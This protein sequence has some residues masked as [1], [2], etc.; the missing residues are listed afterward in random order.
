MACKKLCVYRC[1]PTDTQVEKKFEKTIP[2]KGTCD[3][4][5]HDCDLV[6]EKIIED[7]GKVGGAGGLGIGA[8]IGIGIGFAVGGPLGAL[9]GGLI[10]GGIGLIVGVKASECP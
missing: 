4:K 2:E 6:L 5:Y 1:P 7:S 8:G 3:A 10:G 9:V